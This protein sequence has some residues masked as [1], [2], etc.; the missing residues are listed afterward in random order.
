MLVFSAMRLKPS[1]FDYSDDLVVG[2]ILIIS[3]LAPF[4]NVLIFTSGSSYSWATVCGTLNLSSWFDQYF[5]SWDIKFGW[6]Y[7]VEEVYYC[8]W[9]GKTH[10]FIHFHVSHETHYNINVVNKFKSMISNGGSMKHGGRWW[11][12]WKCETSNGWVFP[13]NLGVFHWNG[14]LW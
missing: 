1:S 9:H 10:N 8:V 6:L 12:M 5:L 4:S 3:L 2:N 13:Q 7:Q 11:M 14:C